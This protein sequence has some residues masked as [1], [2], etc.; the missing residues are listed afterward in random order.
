MR[1]FAERDSVSNKTGSGLYHQAGSSI[2]TQA[3]RRG[4]CDGDDVGSVDHRY[5]ESSSSYDQRMATSIYAYLTRGSLYKEGVGSQNG[6]ELIG[7]GKM[8]SVE[9]TSSARIMMTQSQ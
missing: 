6:M 9:E 2:R 1:G 4:G 3:R 8:A 5:K 7:G